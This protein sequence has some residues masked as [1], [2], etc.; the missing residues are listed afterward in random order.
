MSNAEAGILTAIVTGGAAGLG[1]A[2]CRQLA[3]RGVEVMVADR[4]RAGAE[5]V[6]N[7]CGRAGPKSHA[8]VVDLAAP[9]GPARMIEGALAVAGKVDILVN[10]AGIGKGEAFL[11]IDAASWDA[12]MA[13]NLRAVV[14]A[15]VAVGRHM[16]ERKRGRIVNV[17]SPASRMA[18]PNYTAYAAS[19]A[20]VDSVTRA[21]AVAL[22]PHGILVNSVAP[23]M[24]D[25]ALQ[26]KTEREFAALEGRNDFAAFVAERTKRI[27]LGRRTSCDE[28]AAGI[29]WLA[30]DAPG[31]ITAER[32][33]VSGG[34]DKD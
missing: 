22:G 19:K 18:L 25:T 32:L 34:L 14:L 28:V 30:L 31:Y 24:M 7:E 33:N 26:D 13:I 20:A 4:D 8:I 23:G 2:V 27:P 16:R 17:T 9:E 12:S 3:G 6:A 15:M 10:N 11:D 1:E 5:R 21:A 29:V